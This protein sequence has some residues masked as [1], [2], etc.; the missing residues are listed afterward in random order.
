[1]TTDQLLAET[2]APDAT[3]ARV[4]L[5]ILSLARKLADGPDAEHAAQLVKQAK[6]KRMGRGALRAIARGLHAMVK[7]A[8]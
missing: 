8:E 3:C 2:A 7:A 5:S 4:R 1:M 6:G